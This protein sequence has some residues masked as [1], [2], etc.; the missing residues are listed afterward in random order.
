MAA[1]ANASKTLY[2]VVFQNQNQIYE[3]FVR[4]VYQSELFGFIEIE[5]LVFGERSAVVV[6][7][8]EEKLAHEFANVERSYLPMHSIIRIDEVTERGN[9]RIT[10]S[11]SDT[12]VAPFPTP[13]GRGSN[14]PPRGGDQS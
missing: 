13:Y 4:S 1:S 9:A 3:V 5:Q 10:P 11:G 14:P 6:D 7:P 8:A 2:R 12:K